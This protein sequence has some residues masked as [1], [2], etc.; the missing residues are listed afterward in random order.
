MN[1]KLYNP[2]AFSKYYSKTH[3]KAW[4][5]DDVIFC[6]AIAICIDALLLVIQ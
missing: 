6:L 5:I 4:S 3:W 2:N 1:Y